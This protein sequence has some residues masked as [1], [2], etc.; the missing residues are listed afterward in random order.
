MEK[1]TLLFLHG[2]PDFFAD[3]MCPVQK[4]VIFLIL[5]VKIRARSDFLRELFVDSEGFWWLI[6]VSIK[7]ESQSFLRIVFPNFPLLH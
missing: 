6:C 7:F 2:C 5:F 1:S 3:L 4:S